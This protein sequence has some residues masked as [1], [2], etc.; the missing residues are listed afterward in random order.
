[1]QLAAALEQLGDYSAVVAHRA[2]DRNLIALGGIVKLD[3]HILHLKAAV[4]QLEA[5]AKQLCKVGI[6]IQRGQQQLFGVGVGIVVVKSALR[7]LNAVDAPPHCS[8]AQSQVVDVLN[9]VKWHGVKQ[10]KPFQLIFIFLLLGGIIEQVRHRA[11]TGPQHGNKAH[12]H[13]NG[14]QKA[15]CLPPAAALHPGMFFRGN[16]MFHSCFISQGSQML[17]CPVYHIP[18]HCAKL[19][20]WF[21]C[22]KRIPYSHVF[23]TSGW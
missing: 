17:Q 18:A 1:M 21:F 9:A 23:H 3:G 13:Q 19:C 7:F 14:N 10:H 12:D 16:I 6:H 15:Q 5:G 8:F 2:G 4:G 11:H 22:E 20:P